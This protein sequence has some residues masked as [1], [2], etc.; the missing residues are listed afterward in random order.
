ME[1]RWGEQRRLGDE[2]VDSARGERVGSGEAR[3][4]WYVKDLSFIFAK[5]CRVLVLSAQ[6]K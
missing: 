5:I 2:R 3:G 6:T 1:S 4:G